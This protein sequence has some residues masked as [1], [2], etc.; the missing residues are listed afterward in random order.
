MYLS[1]YVF[2]GGGCIRFDEEGRYVGPRLGDLGEE[3]GHVMYIPWR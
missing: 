3:R 2:T 1:E